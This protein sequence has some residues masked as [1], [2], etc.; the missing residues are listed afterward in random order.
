MTANNLPDDQL[1]GMAI[2]GMQPNVREKLF[3]MDFDD[4]GQLSQWLAMM[5]NQAQRFRRDNC[6]QK[7]DVASEI[8]QSFLEEATKYNN[9]DEIATTKLVWAKEPT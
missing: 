7:G 9:E 5:G 8:D 2:A 6:F 1:P 4:L 3:G